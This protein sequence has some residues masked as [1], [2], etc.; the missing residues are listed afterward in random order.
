MVDDDATNRRVLRGML[1]Q[2]GF[3]ATLD[4]AVPLYEQALGLRCLGRESDEH[5]VRL[6]GL[7]RTLLIS[8]ADDPLR[9]ETLAFA[10]D[11]LLVSDLNQEYGAAIAAV[12]LDTKFPP[13]RASTPKSST[14]RETGGC[15]TA[16]A[17]TA[18]P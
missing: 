7:P 5:R 9:D 17:P 14:R 2:L 11:T 18:P 10:T 8:A 1:R 15:A 13:V 12:F 16:A 4:E 3:E 6:A